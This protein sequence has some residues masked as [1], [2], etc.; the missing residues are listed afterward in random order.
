M[1]AGNHRGCGCTPANAP[2][3][4][5]GPAVRS[6]IPTAC[7]SSRCNISRDCSGQCRN[8]CRRGEC[9]FVPVG[10]SGAVC[11]VCPNIIKCSCRQAGNTAG[12]GACRS[13]IGGM[14]AGN[15]RACGCSPANAP[16]GDGGPAV[17]SY[18]STACGSSRCHICHGRSCQGRNYSKCGEC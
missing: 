17:R 3:G 8:N 12:I 7:G 2:G 16:G 18:I 11:G 15:H 14:A 10:C 6:Y 13:G 1:A 9:H 5:G 4:D